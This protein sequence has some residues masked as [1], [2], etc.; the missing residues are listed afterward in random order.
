MRRSIMTPMLSMLMLCA[1]VDTAR[2]QGSDATAELRAIDRRW[3]IEA[4]RDHKPELLRQIMSDDFLMTYVDGKLYGK[5]REVATVTAEQGRA[6]MMQWDADS[7]DVRVYGDAAV[8]R[9]VFVMKQGEQ[10]MRRLRYTNTYVRRSSGWQV[11]ASHYTAI[12]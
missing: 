11:V 6:V 5:E 10:V 2:A 4:Y 9:G 8:V 12:R 3:V 1:L 7:I